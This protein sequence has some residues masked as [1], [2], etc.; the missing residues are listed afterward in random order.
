MKKILLLAGIMSLFA[1]D[2]SALVIR[3]YVA[4]K[5][6]VALT[7][8]SVKVVQRDEIWNYDHNIKVNKLIMGG[9]AAFG[10]MF[11]FDYRSVRM[12]VEYNHNGKAKKNS[13]A[14]KSAPI[15]DASVQ[16][17]AVFFNMY[18]DFQSNTAWVP[19]IGGGVGAA[20]LKTVVMEES[21]DKSTLAWNVGLG[22]QYRMSRHGSF[23]FGYRYVSYGSFKRHFDDTY[24]YLEN[25]K[26][27]AAA[28]ELYAGFRIT[29]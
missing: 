29:W 8:N 6:K 20:K 24:K 5:G 22:M 14:K 9:S 2:A 17:K 28:H 4:A 16:T 26:V 27:E 10:M 23:D 18:Y 3:P 12:E 11:P 15:I 25:D 19:Y 7:N 21:D 1:F 13:Q